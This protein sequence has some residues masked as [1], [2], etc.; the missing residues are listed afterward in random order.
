MESTSCWDGTKL[1]CFS[2]NLWCILNM[3]DWLFF[4]IYHVRFFIAFESHFISY[5]SSRTS[6]FQTN[7]YI[8]SDVISSSWTL[9]IA[10]SVE[11]HAVL[12]SPVLTSTLNMN[13]TGSVSGILLSRCMQSYL[14]LVWSINL[15][16][17]LDSMSKWFR[18]WELRSGLHWWNT[19]FLISYIMLRV[20]VSWT[21]SRTGKIILIF[22][23]LVKGTS[24]NWLFKSLIQI[25][26]GLHSVHGICALWSYG[27]FTIF[28]R[29]DSV[30]GWQLFLCV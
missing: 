14:R 1:C 13:T 11:D 26:M 16:L 10:R 4:L 20:I 6:C 12:I 30:I 25:Q 22:L 2:Q 3:L 19:N 8:L 28:T 17:A 27:T 5:S 24:Y 7:S 29:L 9:L 15:F 23:S 18:K 21:S